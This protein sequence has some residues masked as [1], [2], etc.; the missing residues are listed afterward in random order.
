VHQYNFT[1]NVLKNDNYLAL[2]FIKM[3]WDDTT[4]L[5]CGVARNDATSMYAIHTSI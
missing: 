3:V 4:R 5:G 1:S 2:M